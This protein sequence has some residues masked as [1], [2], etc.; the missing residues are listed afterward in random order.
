MKKTTW[1]IYM[2][3]VGTESVGFW[4]GSWV[5]NWH[6]Q[7]NF[8][9]YTIEVE[10]YVLYQQVYQS[11]SVWTCGRYRTYWLIVL[12]PEIVQKKERASVVVNLLQSNNCD[13]IHY[14]FSA[15]YESRDVNKSCSEVTSVGFR[16][17]RV[18]LTQ[19][20]IHYPSFQNYRHCC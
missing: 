20:E 13:F 7:S 17:Q 9:N 12:L 3:L 2:H 4:E 15:I 19:S 11:P 14:G 5:H 10:P 1:V 6:V 8:V 16:E 18:Y